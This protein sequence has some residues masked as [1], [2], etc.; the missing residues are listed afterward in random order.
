MKELKEVEGSG[1]KK[2]KLRKGGKR[3]GK[4]LQGKRREAKRREEET[5][6]KMDERAEGRIKTKPNERKEG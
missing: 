3:Q 1:G 6:H 5:N 4:G 2:M